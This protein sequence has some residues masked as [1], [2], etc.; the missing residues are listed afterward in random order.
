LGDVISSVLTNRRSKGSNQPVSN[1][2]FV[3][4]LDSA[5]WRDDAVTS[6]LGGWG[7]SV[8]SFGSQR[9]CLAPQINFSN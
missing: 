3:L 7:L 9:T 4:A 6:H 2:R 8:F 1:E 5:S